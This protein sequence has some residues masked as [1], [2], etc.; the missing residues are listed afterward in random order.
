[1]I[2]D[3]KCMLIAALQ[4]FS[5]H[6]F[7]SL[8]RLCVPAAQIEDVHVPNDNTSNF[9]TIYRSPVLYGWWLKRVRTILQ[10][11]VNP[12]NTRKHMMNLIFQRF[13]FRHHAHFARAAVAAL[14]STLLIGQAWG[15]VS[16][17]VIPLWG[18][19]T[20]PG[21]AGVSL[22][23]AVR[24]NGTPAIP[25]RVVSKIAVP[26]L[27][28]YVPAHPNGAAALIT[29]GGGYTGIV[30]DKEGTEIAKWLNSLGVTAFVLKF[31]L[32]G[33]GH[34][35]GPHVPLQDGQRAMR[36]VRHHATGWGLD[37]QR[38]GVFGFSSGGHTAAMIG[39][40]FAENVYP[41]RD[42]IDTRSARPDFLVLAYGSHS[43]NARS[44]LIDP[45]QAPI[46]PPEKQALYDAYPTDQKVG[47]ATPPTFL[48]HT[49]EDNRVDPRNSVRFYLA[50][51]NQGL[52]GE[53]H[54]FKDGPH[55]VAIR[56]AAGYPVA[57]WTQL[58]EAWL[59]TLKILRSGP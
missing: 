30:I 26:T 59:N 13:Q 56:E 7:G 44:A 51:K 57:A 36:L 49:D 6:D 42:A 2:E 14:A 55:G 31:R 8:K 39:T 43:G 54:I 47:K 21:S 12:T 34:E 15:L 45:K 35:N 1:L 52:T 27:I 37:P 58:C 17:E 22:T 11:V 32:P 38:I 20:P 3:V 18:Q 40:S 46:L 4:Q 50:L 48:M 25:N 9:L 29:P 33:E 24:E 41:A 28:A 19:D 10:G 5:C 16:G 53:L 23:E